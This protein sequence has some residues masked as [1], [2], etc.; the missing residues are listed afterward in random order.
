M[1]VTDLIMS[2]QFVI[3][4]QGHKKAVLLD[5]TVWEEIVA[6]LSDLQ[7]EGQS[8]DD[9]LA[10]AG[11]WAGDDLEQCLEEVYAHRTEAVF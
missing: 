6:K 3:D 4:D 1:T 9:L 10:F 11:T 8:D 7:D 2:A 5:F